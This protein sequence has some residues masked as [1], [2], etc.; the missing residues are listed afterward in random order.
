MT[1]TIS[2]YIGTSHQQSL[3]ACITVQQHT[4]FDYK[5]QFGGHGQKFLRTPTFDPSYWISCIRPWEAGKSTLVKSLKTE[6]D[7]LSHTKH[8]FTQI[9]G[10]DEKIDIIPHDILQQIFGA[11]DYV[12]AGHREF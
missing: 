6:G 7:L 4:P 5:V 2:K 3:T 8:H 12:L 9:S 11:H 1:L 10:V